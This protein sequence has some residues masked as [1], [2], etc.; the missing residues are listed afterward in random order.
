MLIRVWTNRCKQAL[1][2]WAVYYRGTNDD[3]P[4][5]QTQPEDTLNTTR[6]RRKKT[7]EAEEEEDPQRND[8]AVAHEILSWEERTEAFPNHRWEPRT[9]TGPMVEVKVDRC[10]WSQRKYT[11]FPNRSQTQARRFSSR[12]HPWRHKPAGG[13]QTKQLQ[14]VK[15]QF[16]GHGLKW[17]LR[18][19]TTA[20]H[21]VD[22]SGARLPRLPG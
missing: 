2:K 8:D 19:D 14:D 15:H 13:Q 17:Y 4:N 7:P 18:L 3:E 20:G 5:V 9:T 21:R 1:S 16:D 22:H 11:S 6:P 10:T 12:R